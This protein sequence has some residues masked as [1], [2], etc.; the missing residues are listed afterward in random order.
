MLKKGP[1]LLPQPA[2]P[3][4]A[5]G[6][7]K[8]SVVLTVPSTPTERHAASAERTRKQSMAVGADGGP[9]FG[10]VSSPYRRLIIIIIVGVA[11]VV[12]NIIII[13]CHYHHHHDHHNRCRRLYY[14]HH[15]HIIIISTTTTT[16]IIII[17]ITYIIIITFNP[18]VC[19]CAGG[20]QTAEHMEPTALTAG[21]HGRQPHEHGPAETLPGKARQLGG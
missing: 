4:S 5:K 19:V 6:S 20:S 7:R 10:D 18:C 3:A 2:W 14:H 13:S 21:C 15:H 9:G 17:I 12:I 1:F 8:Q 16:T 11:V